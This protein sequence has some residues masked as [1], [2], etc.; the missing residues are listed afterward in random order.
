MRDSDDPGTSRESGTGLSH[1]PA[2]GPEAAN[3]NGI[4]SCRDLPVKQAAPPAAPTACAA[5]TLTS[6][7]FD[8]DAAA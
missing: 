7:D 1:A 5:D 2:A 3:F 8:L 4:G 6:E